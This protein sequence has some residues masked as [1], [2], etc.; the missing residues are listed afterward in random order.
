MKSIVMVALFCLSVYGIDVKDMLKNKAVD[1]MLS[2]EEE[3]SLTFKDP[4]LC[5]RAAQISLKEYD[6]MPVKGYSSY[7]KYSSAMYFNAGVIYNEIGDHS[8]KIKMYKKALEIS[9]N[10]APANL[11]LGIAYYLGKGVEKS[12]I[13]TYEHWRVAAK[14]DNQIAQNNLDVLCR[15]SPWA[16]K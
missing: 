14:Q 10:Y 8:N 4:M 5:V 2:C 13:K 7:Q 15:E 12:L 3:A 16:C 6:A 9:P 11:N 1:Q